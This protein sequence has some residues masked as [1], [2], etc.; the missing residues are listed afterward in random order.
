MGCVKCIETIHF[1]TC[2]WQ[3]M[4]APTEA[5]QNAQFRRQIVLRFALSEILDP[6]NHTQKRTDN[7]V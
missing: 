2:R 1:N 3:V 5:D 4:V 6:E 7:L